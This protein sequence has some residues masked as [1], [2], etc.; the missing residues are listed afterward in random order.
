MPQL[1]FLMTPFARRK[2]ER[3]R[4]TDLYGS[5]VKAFD[6]PVVAAGAYVE[7]AVRSQYPELQKYAPIDYIQ[8]VNNDVVDLR[9]NLN[10][11]GGDSFEVPAGTV[12]TQKDTAF[13][14]YRITNLDA[15]TDTTLTKV[16]VRL[17]KQA[18]DADS[19]LRGAV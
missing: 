14:V 11:T 4:R 3:R 2:L 10:G 12:V 19:V 1:K 13:D 15:A 8:V 7:Y 6:L 16:R 18:K 9:V 5:P 17:Q